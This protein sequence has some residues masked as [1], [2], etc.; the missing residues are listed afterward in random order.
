MKID[1]RLRDGD[2]LAPRPRRLASCRPWPV[3]SRAV[4][5]TRI[6]QTQVICYGTESFTLCY[7]HC[8][9]ITLPRDATQSAVLILYVVCTSV[10]PS[11]TLRY[12]TTEEFN[13][14]SKVECYQLNLAHTAHICM[15]KW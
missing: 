12:D 15:E 3:C 9:K 8:T 4:P 11:V 2:W 6:H 1:I 10:R 13:M 5:S 14:N 7:C